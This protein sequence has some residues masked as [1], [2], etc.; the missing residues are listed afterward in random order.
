MATA[1]VGPKNLTFRWQRY[2]YRAWRRGR[3]AAWLPLA[4]YEKL[5]PLP[6]AEVRRQLRIEPAS[7][8]HPGGI[9]V[10]SRVISR[11]EKR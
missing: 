5:L 3:R 11:S 10:E 6:L 4:S 1:I 2:L 8:A 9:I 7:V